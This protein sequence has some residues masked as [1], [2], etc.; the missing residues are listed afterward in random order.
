MRDKDALLRRPSQCLRL[1]SCAADGVT[2]ES[3]HELPASVALRCPSYAALS[4]RPPRSRT[5][6][7][8]LKTACRRTLAAPFLGGLR[9]SAQAHFEL[10]RRGHP[11]TGDPIPMNSFGSKSTLTS[12]GKSYEIYRLKALEQKGFALTKLPYSLRI[13]LEN[14]L[15][16]EDG[17]NVTAEDIE[18][19]A[20]WDAKAEPEPRDRLHA[21]ARADA[22]LHR[23]ARDR[24]SGGDARCDE[25]AGRRSGRRSIRCMPAELVIDHSVQVDEFGTAQRLRRQRRARV[26]AQPRA[27]RIPEVGTDGVPQLLRGAAGHGHLPPGESRVPGARGLHHRGRT[28]SRL[29]LSRHAGRHRLAHHDDQR[30]GRAGLGRGRHR[31]RGGDAGPA[32]LHAG[33]A[34]GRLQAD[35]Q[36]ARGRDGDRPGADR[37]ARCCASWAWWASSS[38]STAP[39]IARAAA[40]RSRHHRQ[41]GAG[42]R[43]DLRHLPGRRGDAALSAPHRPQRRADR[44]GRG[45]LQGAG[46]L[47]HAGRAGGG[48]HADARARSG[49]GRAE[50]GRTE[51]AAGSRAAEGCGA[52]ASRKQLPTLLAPNGNQ[53][54]GARRL[55]PLGGRGRT[56][57]GRP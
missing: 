25:D 50:R 18:F 56:H 27:L 54:L 11:D 19:L 41:H 37:D 13:L 34:G 46:T 10:L 22:G 6:S 29:A 7:P 55:Q 39:G 52:K 1:S 4:P 23:R 42:V 24:R 9:A 15:R 57:A 47:P 36:A 2:L 33:A 21:G 43:R 16:R 26:P 45:V 53:P 28:A 17:V 35:R 44:A 32:G 8:L 5:H 49:D 38:S 3:G 31:G 51:A 14:L 20:K 48:V 30:P 40:G 12:N